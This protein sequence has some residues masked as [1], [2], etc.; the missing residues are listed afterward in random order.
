MIPRSSLTALVFDVFACPVSCLW[1][2]PHYDG[3]FSPGYGIFAHFL[4]RIQRS[5]QSHV[6][7]IRE[8]GEKATNQTQVHAAHE[9]TS[10]Q[11]LHLH[12][13]HSAGIKDG[14]DLEELETKLKHNCN[15]TQWTKN[16]PVNQRT[17]FNQISQINHSRNQVNN[18]KST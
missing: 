11:R 10:T 12:Q 1:W 16:T 4:E 9:D 18:K 8:K 14:K 5:T 17:Q 15:L 3:V 7:Q 13:G 6:S 2:T